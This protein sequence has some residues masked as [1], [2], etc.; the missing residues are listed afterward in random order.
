M[1]KNWWA[2]SATFLPTSSSRCAA[3][4]KQARSRRRSVCRLGDGGVAARAHGPLAMLHN[5]SNG[6]QPVTHPVEID[7][8]QHAPGHAGFIPAGQDKYLLL[9]CMLEP[10]IEE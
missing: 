10:V 1:L 8:R 4:R 2:I 5:H 3:G 9:K 6:L 7:E